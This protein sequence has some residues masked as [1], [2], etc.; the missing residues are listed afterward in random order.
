MKRTSKPQPAI[1]Y[2]VNGTHRAD[3]CEPL[4]N[5]KARGDLYHAA[6][7]HGTYPGQ[8]M[9]VKMLPEL[10][11]A[12][13]WD[14]KEDQNWGLPKHRN[15]G[16][17]LGYLTRGTLDFTVDDQ[18]YELKAGDFTVT[19]PWQPHTV[20]NPNV[21]A[22]RMHWLILDVGV[23]RPND[24][25]QWPDW[26]NFSEHDLAGLTKLLSFNEQP[27]WRGNKQIEKCFEKIAHHVSSDS[28][29][30]VQTRL[31]LYINE[32]FLEAYEML[33]TKQIKL[34]VKLGSTQRSVEMFLSG[35]SEHLDYPWTLESMAEHCNLGRS[36]FAHY[37]K[38]ITNMTA[39]DYLAHCRVEKSK[40]LLANA[41]DAS[42][43][44]IA[45]SC[46]FESSQY[47]AT[48]FKKKTGISPTQYRKVETEQQQKSA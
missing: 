23:R 3:T 35:L 15:E 24:P 46:G 47:F 31:M 9:P 14:A 2:D 16:I 7:A 25:W 10:C 12:C 34:D 41:P 17:E 29:E 45:F 26:I 37:C 42:V 13:V 20:G 18:H 8:R 5:A 22:S 30:D 28:P 19:R 39:A 21:A 44:D 36:R 43:T 27:V 11:V 4:R 6:F 48:V 32:L 33:K 40:E 38:R 1:F